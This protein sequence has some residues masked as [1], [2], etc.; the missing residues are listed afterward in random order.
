MQIL[1]LEGFVQIGLEL[2]WWE[3]HKGDERNC[4]NVKQH[5]FSL[6]L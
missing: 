1:L 2:P 4:E 3:H 5:L 6:H